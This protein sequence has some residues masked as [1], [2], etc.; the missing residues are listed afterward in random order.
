MNSQL[1]ES[2]S[3]TF[4]IHSSDLLP[5]G[6]TTPMPTEAAE[7]PPLVGQKNDLWGAFMKS[8]N[9]GNK[10]HEYVDLLRYMHMIEDVSPI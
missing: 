1:I 9:K 7:M 10:R 4:T 6:G 2:N 5:S 8:L 3:S